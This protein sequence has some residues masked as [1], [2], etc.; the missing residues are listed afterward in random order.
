MK[1]ILVLHTGGTISMSQNEAGHV[2]LNKQNPLTQAT[3]TLPKDI[4]MVTETCFNLPSACMTP[5]EMLQLQQRILKATTQ[6][7]DGVV[8]SHGTDT[9]EE[10]A[11]FL[12]LTLPKTIAVVV[13]GAMRSSNEIGSDGLHNF[14]TA[15]QTA[16]T[17]SAKTKGVLVVLNDEI[18]AAR[19]VTKTH[20]TNVATFKSP[21]TGPI[22]LFV[23]NTPTF[24]KTEVVDDHLAIDQLLDH[25]Y[26]IKA[27]AGMDDQLLKALTTPETKGLVIEALGSGNLPSRIV[28]ALQAI[29]NLHIPIVIVSRCVTGIAQPIYDYNGGGVSLVQMGATFCQGLN[30]PKARLRLLVALSANLQGEALTTYLTNQ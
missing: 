14:L 22:G 28:P 2:A 13:T 15:V 17:P 30:G 11:Y 4:Q 24:F 8:I 3:A 1:K 9:L 12:D 27:Y 25:V 23:H 6:G 18:H 16:A 19:Y 26:L 10:T 21:L 7:F 20:T 29:L 5:N